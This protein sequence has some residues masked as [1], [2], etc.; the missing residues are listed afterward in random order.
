MSATVGIRFIVLLYVLVPLLFGSVGEA[1][2]QAPTPLVGCCHCQD[3]ETEPGAVCLDI[4]GSSA[5]EAYCSQPQF[6]CP[7]LAYSTSQTCASGCGGNPPISPTPTITP[8][9]TMT[10]TPTATRTDTPPTPPDTPTV[11]LTPTPFGCCSCPDTNT[12]ASR[13]DGCDPTCMLEEFRVCDSVTGQCVEATPTRTA[14]NTPVPANTHTH[15]PTVTFTRTFTPT[16]T[17]TPTFQ[18]DHYKCYQGKGQRGEKRMRLQ[19]SIDGGKEHVYRTQNPLV[20]TPAGRDGGP[21][22]ANAEALTCYDLRY[23][24]GEAKL[25]RGK[26]FSVNSPFPEGTPVSGPL[27]RPVRVCVPSRLSVQ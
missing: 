7:S 5:C 13:S 24:P 4:I 16:F 10:N 19:D 20:C 6:A 14:T 22:P 12:C 26:E 8:T 21:I 1:W 3:C 25:P 17:P 11:T 15:T 18:I 23:Q 27:R 2:A 9:P